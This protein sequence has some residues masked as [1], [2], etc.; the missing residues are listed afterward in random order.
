MNSFRKVNVFSQKTS[1]RAGLNAISQIPLSSANM[2]LLKRTAIILFLEVY[3][4]KEKIN[5]LFCGAI[6][7]VT[8]EFEA[9]ELLTTTAKIL[10]TEVDVDLVVSVAHRS[11]RGKIGAVGLKRYLDMHAFYF[12]PKYPTSKA[13]VCIMHVYS[14]NFD[15]DEFSESGDINLF[16]I[17]NY[18]LL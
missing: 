13:K 14:H 3:E 8:D 7:P 17:D 12:L 1:W 11:L 4:M 9:K 5:I 18:W 16:K 15:V 10:K 6:V 2:Y